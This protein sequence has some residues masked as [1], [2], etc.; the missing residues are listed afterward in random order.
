MNLPRAI[1]DYARAMLQIEQADRQNWKL[2]GDVD[3]PHALT[4]RTG[5][6]NVGWGTYTPTLTNL[7]NL[8]GS[9]AY[10]CQYMRVGDVVTVSG[11]IDLDPTAAGAAVIGISLPIASNFAT[12]RP[13]IGVGSA[14]TLT[15]TFAIYADATN[16]RAEMQGVAVGTSSHAICFTFTYRVI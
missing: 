9:T 7:V 11:S 4:I 5:T 6:G 1:A 16:D 13:C 14:I 3:H 12:S 15:E 10:E 8:D 2:T